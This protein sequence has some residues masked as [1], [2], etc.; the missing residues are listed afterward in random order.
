ML[1][2]LRRLGTL[3]RPPLTGNQTYLDLSITLGVCGR[4]HEINT[5]LFLFF[6]LTKDWLRAET[7]LVQ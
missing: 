5:F 3:I 1:N 2:L 6:C 4:N 7:A